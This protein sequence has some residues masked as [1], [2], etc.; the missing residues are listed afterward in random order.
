MAAMEEW[1]R[2]GDSASAE[3]MLEMYYRMLL[4]RNFEERTSKLYAAG[5]VPGFVHLSIGQEASAVGA[6][7]PLRST[8]GI[9][10]NHRG[11]GH[12]LAKGADPR[13]MFAEL[14]GKAAGTGGGMGGSMHIADFDR[15]IY[16]ANGIVGAGLPIAVG[17][18]EG[19]RQQRREDIVVAFFG[20]GA[21]AQGA[22]HEAVNLAA[23]RHLPIL[24]V[25]ENNQYSEF[26]PFEEQ[27]PVPVAARA[28]AYGIDFASVDGND[29]MSVAAAAGGFAARLRGGEGPFL[30]EAVTYRWNGHY[31]GDPMSYRTKEELARWKEQDPI[32]ALA[33][34]LR[35]LIDSKELS[36]VE[37]RAQKV[38]D[39]AEI[40]GEEA[41]P[42]PPSALFDS[43]EV[44]RP[45]HPAASLEPVTT[46]G[47]RS[48]KAMNAVHDALEYSLETDPSVLVAGVDVGAG[49]VFGLTRGMREKFGSRVFNTPISESAVI[50][51]AVGSAMTGCKPVVE[52]M[53]FD[54]VGVAFD[55]IMNQ[56]AKI[57]FMTG[58]RAPASMVIRTQF[59]SGKSSAAQHSQSLE[60]LL[61]HIPGLTVVMPST[62]EDTYGLLRSAILDPNPVVFVEHRLQYGLKGVRP[63]REYTIP[64][65]QAA[66]RREGSDVTVVT[67]SRMVHVALAA[68]EELAGEGVDVEVVDLRTVAPLDIEAILCSVRKTN[69]LVI[70]HEA[71][72]RGG[73]GAEIAAQVADAG[74]WHLDAPIKRV[75]PPFTPAPYSPA[76]EKLWVPDVGEVIAAV[77]AVML[78]TASA[79]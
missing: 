21:I 43:V 39:D 25:C 57:H 77:R 54:F 68:A 33:Y 62:A 51:L 8:D 1:V 60:A 16:G 13:A 2:F 49:N 74:V 78:D 44:R 10:S 5:R 3:D 24:F 76:L 34:R 14:M 18:A 66:I 52:I 47:E 35:D 71:H 69:K 7:W 17:V 6:C 56:A 48:F 73:L 53:Y 9:V 42:P 30:L 64:L 32:A 55:Q 79:S 15:G 11:H 72:G 67:W 27:H 50:G 12:C 65:G 38:I 29:V 46:A 26:S 22:F 61:A 75:S 70:A 31:E 63:E 37:R 58:G 40:Y 59:G 36:A 28:S 20:D 41:P 19:F 23:I 4:I 45:P